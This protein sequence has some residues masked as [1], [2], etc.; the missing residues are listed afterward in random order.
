[1]NLP[2]DSVRNLA[3]GDISRKQKNSGQQQGN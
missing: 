3:G 2:S 1:M